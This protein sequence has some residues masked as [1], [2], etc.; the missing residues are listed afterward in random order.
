MDK[1]VHIFVIFKTITYFKFLEL[2]RVKFQ[3]TKVWRNLNVFKPFEIFDTVQTALPVTVVPGPRVSDP[4]PLLGAA[5]PARALRPRA[6][7]GHRL[8]RQALPPPFFSLL[9]T[10]ARPGPPSFRHT[11]KRCHLMPPPLFFSPLILPRKHA[12]TFRPSPPFTSYPR[13]LPE[14][15]RSTAGAT[16]ISG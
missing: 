7:A 12:M 11:V 6:G 9:H 14:H 5:P 13:P 3:S 16:G 4:S 1:V 8:P 15:R 10:D 2:G